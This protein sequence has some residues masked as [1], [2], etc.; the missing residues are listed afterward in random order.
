MRDKLGRELKPGHSVLYAVREGDTAA[1]RLAEVKAV[2]ETRIQVIADGAARSTW[3]SHPSRISR[4]V[5][6]S[7]RVA[8]FTRW[9]AETGNPHGYDDGYPERCADYMEYLFNA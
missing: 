3:L 2:E 1:M 5:R 8:V 4:V 7:E 9:L 6:R